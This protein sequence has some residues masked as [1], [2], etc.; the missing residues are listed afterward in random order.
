V[1]NKVDE[2]LLGSDWLE[3]YGAKW[4]FAE[5][6]VTLGD[7]CIKVHRRRREGIC[8]RVVVAHDCMVPAK[9]EANITV[10]MED[11]GITLPLATGLWNRK[12]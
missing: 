4:D 12:V 3:K 10:R 7:H 9:H 5:G 11:N 8:R 1:S 6:T 2:F